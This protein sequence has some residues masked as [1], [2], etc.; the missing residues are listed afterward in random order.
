HQ[1]LVAVPND[2]YAMAPPSQQHLA[3]LDDPIPRG[4]ANEIWDALSREP[5]VKNRLGGQIALVPGG[6][7]RALSVKAALR[8][9]P[10]EVEW[11]AIHD[12][13]RPLLSQELIDRTLAA[14]IEYGAAAPA[15][16][17]QLTIKQAGHA[18]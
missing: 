7:N 3:R 5:S 12:A 14:A 16:P 6:P 18:L 4:R 1:I 11:V 9:V 2:P 13:A 10:A 15:L 8:L 17:V